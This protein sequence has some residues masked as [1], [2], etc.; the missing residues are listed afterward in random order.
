M[1]LDF[2]NHRIERLRTRAEGLCTSDGAT[3]A[4]G[5]QWIRDAL[6]WLDSA[7]SELREAEGRLDV[8]HLISE[9]EAW[10]FRAFFD[11]VPTGFLITDLDGV[12]LELNREAA[13]ILGATCHELIGGP[14]QPH[15][16]DRGRCLEAFS[17]GL[18]LSDFASESRVQIRGAGSSTK[19]EAEVS[20]RPDRAGDSA[21]LDWILRRSE[22][23]AAAAA[24]QAGPRPYERVYGDP[25]APS[26]DLRSALATI[27]NSAHLL[28]MTTG[29]DDARARQSY[30]RIAK[31][32]A[33]IARWIDAPSRRPEVDA[34]ARE[35]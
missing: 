5:S 31:Q 22:I 20:R 2:L 23:D 25:A 12:I 15:L 24:S 13:D 6:Q 32:V 34:F 9:V 17:S 11:R 1:G 8:A 33:W 30:E 7:R 3:Q 18:D 21:E 14:I 26:C 19:A 10:R 4:A 29:G 28:S 27:L 35:D 16:V